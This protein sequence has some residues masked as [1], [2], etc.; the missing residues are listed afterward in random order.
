MIS[1]LPLCGFNKS[2]RLKPQDVDLAVLTSYRSSGPSSPS[3]GR[4]RSSPR[5][6]GG[7][8]LVLMRKCRRFSK[9]DI[10]CTSE[11]LHFG[12]KPDFLRMR[13]FR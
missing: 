4:C 13:T 5:S 8:R 11:T 7:A 9:A 12:L 10:S 3:P 2:V 1:A 6:F